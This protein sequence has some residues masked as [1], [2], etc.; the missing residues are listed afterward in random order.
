MSAGGLGGFTKLSG[1]HQ[2]QE[3]QL[4]SFRTQVWKVDAEHAVART[5]LKGSVLEV[6]L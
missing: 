3:V 5:E 2:V 6:R 1:L 4:V